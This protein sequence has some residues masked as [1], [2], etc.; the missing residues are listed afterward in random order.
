MTSLTL[1]LQQVSVYYGNQAAIEQASLSVRAGE[2]MALVGPSGCGKSSLL[3][4]INR[5]TDGIP[6]CR[7]SGTV[8]LGGDALSASQDAATLRRRIGMVF[9][10]PN[11]F[12][13]SI[14]DNLRFPLAEHGVP[15]RERDRRAEQVLRAVGLWE[16]VKGRLSQSALGLSGGQQQRLCI[17]RALVLEPQVLLLDEPCS[18]LDPVSSKVVEEL[19]VSLKGRYTLLMVT[20]NLAQA[21][22]IADSVTVCWM[23]EGCGCVVESNACHLVFEHPSHPITAAYCAGAAG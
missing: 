20:H 12:P 23:Q 8:L 19:I 7:V 18:A 11:P 17:A 13:L 2:L 15:R 3:A 21:R 1:E 16:E 10:Q 14:I 4:S 22:R 6:G 5:M 9:Q